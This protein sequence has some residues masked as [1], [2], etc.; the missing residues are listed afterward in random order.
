MMARNLVSG[1]RRIS[2]CIK[3]G[4]LERFLLTVLESKR[5]GFPARGY[6]IT[7]LKIRAQGRVYLPT[8]SYY[9][10]SEWTL[11]AG[12]SGSAERRR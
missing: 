10:M 11:P 12:V 3:N 4:W 8:A 5:T 6:R 7:W 2:T 1:R 9:E